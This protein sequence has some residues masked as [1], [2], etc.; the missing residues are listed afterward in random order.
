MIVGLDAKFQ[1]IGQLLERE[2]APAR[3][4]QPSS[5]S[6]PLSELS[7]LPRLP[8]QSLSLFSFLVWQATSRLHFVPCPPRY[9]YHILI[10]LTGLPLL[11]DGLLIVPNSVIRVS[12][13][14]SWSCFIRRRHLF[15]RH[16][17]YPRGPCMFLCKV[18]TGVDR[19]TAF[20]SPIAL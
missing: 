1:A 5:L 9:N 18:I 15:P 20:S 16:Y 11:S 19:I 13:R 8:S 7:P 12:F 10:V 3:R 14:V 4:P 6:E 17:R 2:P